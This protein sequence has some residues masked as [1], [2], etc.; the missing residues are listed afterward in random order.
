MG[1]VRLAKS[2]FYLSWVVPPW[3][4]FCLV[5]R[6]AGYVTRMS[7]GVGGALSD[8]RPYPDRLLSKKTMYL[9]EVEHLSSVY[10]Y[11]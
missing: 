1:G 2:L 8:G 6:I 4:S 3:A 10:R 5:S 7:G 9:L 11:I